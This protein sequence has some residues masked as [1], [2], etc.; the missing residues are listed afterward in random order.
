ML[1]WAP[2]VNMQD[3]RRPKNLEFAVQIL[4]KNT[5]KCKGENVTLKN[6]LVKQYQAYNLVI[7]ILLI[8]LFI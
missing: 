7:L 3:K 5:V 8:C 4:N 2:D 6:S 1:L